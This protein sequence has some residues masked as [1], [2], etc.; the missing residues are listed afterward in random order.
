MKRL[1][2]GQT[3]MIDDHHRGQVLANFDD[4]NADIHLDKK[5]N[6][7]QYRIRVP[8]NSNRPVTVERKGGRRNIDEIPQNI[9][10]EVQSSFEDAVK[11]DEFVK[12]IISELKNF[13]YRDQNRENDRNRDI[14]K[15][16]GALRRISQHFGLGWSNR[17][18]RCFI[19]KYK[20]YGLR[21]MATVTDGPDLYYLS[22]DKYRFVISD[23]FMIGLHDRRFWEEITFV[24][25]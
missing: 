4:P 8:L 12:W 20:T 10:R 6:D 7:G 1:I 22:V 11:R 24:E 21:C 5:A 18:V 25:G 14:N 2:K 9:V 15:A 19:K 3:I 13:P 16:F 17:N 23:Y